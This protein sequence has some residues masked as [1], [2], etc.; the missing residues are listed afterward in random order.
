MDASNPEVNSI[1]ESVRQT[2]AKIARRG[3]E[4]GL[5]VHRSARRWERLHY[6]LGGLAVVLAAVSAGTGLASTAGRVPAAVLALASGAVTA[7]A[8]F[9]GSEKRSQTKYAESAAWFK[10]E[11]AAQN[12]LDFRLHNDQWLTS[13]AEG[14]VADLRDRQARLISRETVDDGKPRVQSSGSSFLP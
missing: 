2:L 5:K 7:L 10:L 1:R 3:H 9:F 8:T 4:N 14:D 6:V 12:M 13:G 11:D